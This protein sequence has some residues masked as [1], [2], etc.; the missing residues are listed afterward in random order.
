MELLERKTY[1]QSNVWA[2]L[3]YNDRNIDGERDFCKQILIVAIKD[4][5]SFNGG[6]YSVKYRNKAIRWFN[7]KE[8]E[9]GNFTFN[10]VIEFLFG[11]N[12]DVEGV[13]IRINKLIKTKKITGV[14]NINN[15]F[16]G[17]DD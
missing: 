3:Q 7:S 9:Y 1:R 8:A 2:M 6:K 17:I 11:D 10:R 12:V 4:A 16:D 5:V 15:M 14:K 13:R